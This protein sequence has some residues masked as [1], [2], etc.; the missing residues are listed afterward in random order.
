MRTFIM[1]LVLATIL[2]G[3]SKDKEKEKSI[4]QLQGCHES[5]ISD[6]NELASR[7]V[8]VWKLTKEECY[9]S[10][11]YPPYQV[12]LTVTPQKTFTLTNNGQT[13]SEGD[14]HFYSYKGFYNYSSSWAMATAQLEIFLMG[15]IILCD[16]TLVFSKPAKD[17]CSRYFKKVL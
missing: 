5:Q 10:T 9:K 16:N 17:N 7:M 11:Y 13:R 14:F 6:T 2:I 3:C 12:V 8:G 4:T 15:S 1:T